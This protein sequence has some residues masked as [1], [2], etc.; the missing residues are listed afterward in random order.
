MPSHPRRTKKSQVKKVLGSRGTHN[1]K[2]FGVARSAQ[3]TMTP[4]KSRQNKMTMKKV[5]ER[6]D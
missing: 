3:P 4:L 6:K 1:S 2:D 5:N